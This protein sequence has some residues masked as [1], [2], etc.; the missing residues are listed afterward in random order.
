MKGKALRRALQTTDAV[1]INADLPLIVDT[2]EL[3]TPD[4]AQEILNNNKG[5]RPVNWKQVEEYSS[6]MKAG[7]F[8]LTAQGIVIDK[9]GNL[10][11]GQTRLWAVMLS[12]CSVYMRVSR[13]NEPDTGRL[14]DRGRQQ[15]ARDLGSRESGKKHSPSEASIARGVCALSGNMKPTKDELGAVIAARSSISIALLKDTSGMKKTKSVL[16]ILAAISV[17]ASDMVEARRLA[18]RTGEFADQLD[19][20]LVPHTASGCWGRGAAFGLAL[21]HARKIVE[22]GK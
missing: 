9:N 8:K 12:N 13:G 3:I 15:S 20:T 7:E 11:T 6:M 17:V 16:M 22:A 14:L 1:R 19:V 2:T 5:N 4:V 10:L 21:E 18:I